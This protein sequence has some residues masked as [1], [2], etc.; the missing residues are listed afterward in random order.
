MK[1]I[2]NL[3]LQEKRV[4]RKYR[5]DIFKK[6]AHLPF[7]DK[8]I[9]LRLIDHKILTEGLAMLDTPRRCSFTTHFDRYYLTNR[10]NLIDSAIDVMN[11]TEHQK[12]IQKRR[13]KIKLVQA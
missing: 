13:N 12:I 6:I 11:K 9:V 3:E 1:K 8:K 5:K 10:L 2:F 7:S 4:G